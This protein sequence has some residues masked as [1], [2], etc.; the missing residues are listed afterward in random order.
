[1]DVY[2]LLD[3]LERTSSKLEKTKL[4]K[5]MEDSEQLKRIFFYA[6]NP[7]YNYGVRIE[8]KPSYG[9][10]LWTFDSEKLENEFFS[11]LDRLRAR[12]VTGNAARTLVKDFFKRA[13]NNQD[14]WLRRVLNRDMRAGVQTTINKVWPSLIPEFNI[15]LCSSYKGGDFKKLMSVEPKL[16]GIRT[17]FI[18]AADGTSQALSRG[19]KPVQNCG[20][21]G[22]V[23]AEFPGKVFDGELLAEDWNLSAGLAHKHGERD[24]RLK[25]N[26][27]D[28]LTLEEWAAQKC[29]RILSARQ[30]E[31]K[32]LCKGKPYIVIVPSVKASKE[33]DLL[34]LAADY[35]DAGFEGAVVKDPD[36]TYDFGRVK[37][38]QKIK[39]EDTVDL[40]ITGFQE[41][42][43]KHIGRL[44]AILCQTEDGGS[45]AIGGGFTDE[46]RTDF[47][48]RRNEMIGKWVEVKAQKQK[49]GYSSTSL[50]FPVF[51]RLRED[52]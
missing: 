28:M 26:V 14:K 8:E 38:W 11:L 7:Y 30:K 41:G 42:E 48:A 9:I 50:R 32:T 45:V 46:Q 5:S 39:F 43:G 40:E 22:E 31:L 36:S 2:K 47:W 16:D 44:G 51:V 37:T 3:E 21:I 20:H 6:M 15:Q 35:L 29:T 4:L 34:K 1:M 23:L 12:E 27:F 10:L 17:I 33:E 25:Y 24:E 13:G 49:S 19:G 18:V 52:K